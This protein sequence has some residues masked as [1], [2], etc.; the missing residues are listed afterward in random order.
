MK[1]IIICL[2]VLCAC[3]GEIDKQ[4]DSSFQISNNY[5]APTIPEV[6]DPVQDAQ[7]VAD[8]KAQLEVIFQGSD[9]YSHVT[10]DVILLKELNGV[11]IIW[12]ATKHSRF[13]EFYPYTANT[14]NQYVVDPSTGKF[15]PIIWSPI[16]AERDISFTLVASFKKHDTFEEYAKYFYCSTS[17]LDISDEQAVDYDK[18]YLTLSLASGDTL[19]NVR[20]DIDLPE[21]GN[22]G[23]TI[24]WESSD[25]LTIDSTGDVRPPQYEMEAN[26]SITLTA[27]ITKGEFQQQKV[28]NVVCP[29]Q[30]Y[31]FN[32]IA[33]PSVVVNLSFNGGLTYKT[34]TLNNIFDIGQPVYYKNVDLL[35]YIKLPAGIISTAW[36]H[37]STDRGRTFTKV[38]KTSYTPPLGSIGHFYLM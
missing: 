14:T 28:F 13:S 6:I 36:V 26:T 1:K 38:I 9:T 35:N 34:F 29:K 25:P 31:V 30:E 15:Y 22:K 7:D 12:G 17:V 20:Q 4:I 19:T 24:T 21:V 23:S 27:T 2:L 32:I 11:E 18:A 33:G 8:V 3:N 10:Q 5:I 16:M 37:Y